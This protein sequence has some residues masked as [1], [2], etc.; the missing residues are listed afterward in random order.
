MKIIFIRINLYFT[1]YDN[2]YFFIIV[3]KKNSAFE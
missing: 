2:E 3:V 1:F